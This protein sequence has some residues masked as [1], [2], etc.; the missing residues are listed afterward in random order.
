MQR[1]ISVT[2]LNNQ[3]KSLLESHYLSVTVEGEVSR[4]TYHSSGHLYFTLKD[5]NSAISCVMFRGN[6]SKLRFRVE[7]G[8]AVVVRGGISV[9]TP[10]GNY[11]INVLSM[12]PAGSGALALA[13][14]QLKK[15]LEAKGYFLSERKK[16]LP[17]IPRHIALVT[18]STGAALQDM[19]R[20]AAQ[21]WPLLKITLFD[22]LVQGEGA[23]ASIA[24]NIEKADRIGADVIIV[25]RGGGSLEDLWAFNEEVVA[26]AIFHARTPVVSAVGH[27][28]DF[29]ISDFVADLRAPTPSA[30]MEM[31]LPDRTEMLLYLDSLMQRFQ[32]GMQTILSR[33]EALLRQ[34]KEMLKRHSFENRIALYTKEIASLQERIIQLF[35][36]RIQKHEEELSYLKER[37]SGQMRRLLGDKERLLHH[38]K[39]AFAQ[40][41]PA[42]RSKTGFA[43]ITKEGEVVA[44]ED[45]RPEDTFR[46]VS[47]KA[48][49]DAVVKKSGRL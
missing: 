39:E 28:I 20:V 6:N 42:K 31:I 4:V 22:T 29:L 48:F 21:R 1:A 19:L 44:L 30:A 5:Q 27:E 11:Q 35:A 17:K 15:R 14:E 9:Y 37:L 47:A 3:I 43:Q 33:K 12:E 38:L 41:D 18:S 45:L 34:Q 10:R 26:D 24:A 13:F 25:G 7:E 49:V 2:T 32:T 16:I 36:Y 8:L 40:S 46:C 23:A